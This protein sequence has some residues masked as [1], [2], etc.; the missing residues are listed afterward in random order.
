MTLKGYADGTGE[1]HNAVNLQKYVYILATS[2]GRL[3]L[4]DMRPSTN[5][6]IRTSQ[7]RLSLIIILK[8]VSSS[9]TRQNLQNSGSLG[10]SEINLGSKR[11]QK[12]LTPGEDGEGGGRERG[13]I[14][15]EVR[16]FY[17]SK[18]KQKWYRTHMYQELRYPECLKGGNTTGLHSSAK[19]RELTAIQGTH[20]QKHDPEPKTSTQQQQH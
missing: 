19:L 20:C 7:P 3:T 17:S 18:S 10:T 8:R 11:I 1:T 14:G 6:F 16:G 5:T 15:F 13:G 4:R 2:D 9:G 12:L